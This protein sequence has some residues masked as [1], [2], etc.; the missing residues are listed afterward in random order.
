MIKIAYCVLS[1]EGAFMDQAIFFGALVVILLAVIYRL[2]K[3]KGRF[4]SHFSRGAF[5]RDL[6][7]RVEAKIPR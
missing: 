6:N 2:G 5:M 3:N 1:K 7:K 4:V